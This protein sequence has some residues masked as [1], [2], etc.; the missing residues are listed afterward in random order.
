M[1]ART[2]FRDVAPERRDDFCYRGAIEVIETFDLRHKASGEKD[3]AGVAS[4]FLRLAEYP[5]LDVGT[6]ESKFS[7]GK[8]FETGRPVWLLRPV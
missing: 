7:N 5:L 8:R 1:Q 6:A 4:G 2:S 3:V